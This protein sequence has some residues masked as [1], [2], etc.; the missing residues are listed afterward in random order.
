MYNAE[1]TLQDDNHHGSTRLHLDLTDTVNVMIWAANLDGESG[2]AVWHIFAASDLP[3]L[4]QFLSEEGIFKGKGDSVHSQTICMTPA[5]L[6]RLFNNYCVRLY[7]VNQDVG[8]AVYI[9][10]GCTHQ[11]RFSIK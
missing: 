6:Q 2:Y 9:P 1:A 4:R 8:H 11:V 3:Y 10:A 7:V 5:L